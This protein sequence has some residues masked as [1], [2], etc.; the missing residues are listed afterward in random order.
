[1]FG[2]ADGANASH[3]GLLRRFGEYL[4]LPSSPLY[5]YIFRGAYS[6]LQSHK[7][8]QERQEMESKKNREYGCIST[9][10]F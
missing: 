8:R 3:V 6:K 1:M 2:V 10:L 4:I 5:C 9:H 7:N